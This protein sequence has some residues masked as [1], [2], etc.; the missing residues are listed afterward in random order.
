MCNVRAIWSPHLSV[1]GLTVQSQENSVWKELDSLV[2]HHKKTL[3]AK[4]ANVQLTLLQQTQLPLISIFF[5]LF[6]Y[7]SSLVEMK[8]NRITE[9][10]IYKCA[11]IVKVTFSLV[12]NF[13]LTKFPFQLVDI[14]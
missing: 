5:T 8:Q 3:S 4:S 7:I 6:L 12:L 10:D 13:D 2:P 9:Y 1:T 14:A 11:K